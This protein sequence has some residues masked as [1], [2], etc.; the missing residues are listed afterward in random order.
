MK[1][2][3][4]DTAELFYLPA[5]PSQH[6]QTLADLAAH[7]GILRRELA[8]ALA[9]ET[10]YS[11]RAVNRARRCIAQI[12]SDLGHFALALDVRDQELAAAEATATSDVLD[13]LER[14]EGEG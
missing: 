12:Q 10:E 6:A 2:R 5:L 8:H 14:R 11:N 9:E 1:H 3:S 4:D 7:V 13:Q